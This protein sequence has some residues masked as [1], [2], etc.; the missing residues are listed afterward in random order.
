MLKNIFFNYYNKWILWFY[1][2]Y[3]G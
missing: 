3:C 2:I 1:N